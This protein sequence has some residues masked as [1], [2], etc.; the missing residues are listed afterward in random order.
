MGV[1]RNSLF[2]ILC[3]TLGDGVK[4]E[5]VQVL[6]TEMAKGHLTLVSDLSPSA[7]TTAPVVA[8]T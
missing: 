2:S 3:L 8:L 4:V 7:V 1:P 6:Q 5:R